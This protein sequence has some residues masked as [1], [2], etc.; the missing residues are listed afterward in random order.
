MKVM[1]VKLTSC[2]TNYQTDY[3]M[4][5]LKEKFELTNNFSEAD[6]IVM[7]GGCC[8][9][10]D[11]SYDTLQAINYVL[12]NKKDTAT[13]Y[14]T[15]CITRGFKDD[16]EL[17][18]VST[19]LE[20]HIDFIVDHYEPHTLLSLLESTPQPRDYYGMCYYDK[21]GANIFI[22]NGCTHTCSF[23]KSNYLHLPLIDAPIDKVKEYIDFLDGKHIRRVE[24]RGLN[25][26]QYGLASTKTPK[27]MELCEYIEGKK[28]I[29]HVELSSFAFSD[30][31]TFGF[32]SDLMHLRK[33]DLINGS[34]ESGSNRILS[35]MNKGFTKEEFLDFVKT[36]T[37][38][39]P[40]K[41]KLNIISGFP[42]ETQE[43]CLETVEVLRQV[44]PKIVNINT[45]SDSLYVPSHHLEQLSEEG[46]RQN[47]K[48][49]TKSLR[50]SFIPYKVNGA[51]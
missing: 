17:Q 34:L 45:Y 10:D 27:L 46:I 28:H 19:S 12:R 35:L 20:E 32:A 9:T 43:D 29:Q 22:Q 42:T 8:C 41:F 44:R 16:P 11:M 4:D 26:S 36:S 40:K 1:V 24:L 18:K 39:H 33:T 15:G 30:A 2:G 37:S 14:L 3:L 6:T 50:R 23:C 5:S 48:V 47:T 7:L 31:I 13:T 25:L 51:N 38:H 49:Y 21:T